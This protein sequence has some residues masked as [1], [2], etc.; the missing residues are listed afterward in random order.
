[1]VD[2]LSCLMVQACPAFERSAALSSSYQSQTIPGNL[3]KSFK[4]LSLD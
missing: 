1:M 4:L 2:N 3:K